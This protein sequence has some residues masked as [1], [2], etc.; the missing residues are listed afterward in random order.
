MTR[1]KFADMHERIS[2]TNP[3]AEDAMVN[4]TLR[5]PLQ[6]AAIPAAVL[7]EWDSKNKS[8]IKK[9]AFLPRNACPELLH[10]P[11]K[12]GGTGLQSMEHEIQ[13]QMRM[14]DEQS[15]V[16]AVARAAKGRHDKRGERSTI[17][18]HTATTLRR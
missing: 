7:R 10:L 1:A 15:K 12:E 2:R 17:Q 18:Y 4:A 6:V 16:G 9:A 8:V 14:L 5:F 3:T 11:K 13:T